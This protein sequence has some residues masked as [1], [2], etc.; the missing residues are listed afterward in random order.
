MKKERHDNP[1]FQTSSN[2]KRGK[3]K[4]KKKTKTKQNKKKQKSYRDSMNIGPR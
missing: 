4:T 1:E 2:D 3:S